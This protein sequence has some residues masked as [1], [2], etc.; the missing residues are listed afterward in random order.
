MWNYLCYA[1][2]VTERLLSHGGCQSACR[3]PSMS[4]PSDSRV[5]RTIYQVIKCIETRRTQS[6]ICIECHWIQTSISNQNGAQSQYAQGR[7]RPNNCFKVLKSS[8]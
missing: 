4:H 1:F 6:A 2:V 5:L 7:V 8:I 3:D